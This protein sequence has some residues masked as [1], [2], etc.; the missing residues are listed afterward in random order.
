M[1]FLRGI[2]AE[3]LAGFDKKFLKKKSKQ[4]FGGIREGIRGSEGILEKFREL[5]S[6]GVMGGILE[7]LLGGLLKRIHGRISDA[8]FAEIPRKILERRNC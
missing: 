6:E 1:K 2:L 3:V 4:I 7:E 5:V 8:I